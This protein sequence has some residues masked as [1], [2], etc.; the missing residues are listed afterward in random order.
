MSSPRAA[1]LG[2][3]LSGSGL[4]GAPVAPMRPEAARAWES[5]L[6]VYR[7]ALREHGIVGSAVVV[8]HDGGVLAQAAEGSADLST[9]RAVDGDTLFHWASITKTFTGIAILQLRDHGRLSLEDPI[10]KYVPEL[11][12][13]HNPFGDISG[14]TIRHL[15]THSAG[16]R[17][18]TWPWGGDK[19]W[20]PFEPPRWEQL[21]AMLPY[22]EIQFPPGSR[23]SYSNPG[24][25]FLGKTIERL[26]NEDYEVYVDKN[27]LRPL[28]MLRTFFDRAPYHLLPHRS[29]SYFRTDD[30]LT[31]TPFDFDSGITVSN[32]GLNG[33][34]DDMARYLA[35]L[36]GDASHPAAYETVLRRSS[37]EEMFQ[38]GRPVREEGEARVAMG[39]SFFVER[40]RGR[41]LIAHGGE[42]NGFLSHL[43]LDPAARTAYV[44][45]FNTD[46]T[47]AARGAERNTHTLD[48]R[49]R[50]LLLAGVFAAVEAKGTSLSP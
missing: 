6:A 31:E 20:H 25:V 45:A 10:V 26:T 12:E 38:A 48:D 27:I 14:V 7:D 39:L 11:R 35:F 32:G 16:F 15:L 42:Q 17:E 47:S 13:V 3:V 8:V 43:Y 50:D 2:V 24:V 23:F 21:A 29:H 4:A 9:G 41:V 44:L 28:G 18:P 33:P 34:L 40:R 19:P 22:T 37:L 46:T 49:L 36:M 1:V 30:G 5:F